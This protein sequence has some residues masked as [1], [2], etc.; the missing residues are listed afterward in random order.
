M[1]SP[2][3][4]ESSL[5]ANGVRAYGNPS[6][7]SHLMTSP[8]L[9][10]SHSTVK[11]STRRAPG[12]FA[13]LS[14]ALSVFIRSATRSGNVGLYGAGFGGMQ[15]LDRLGHLLRGQLRAACGV[16][17]R[18]AIELSARFTQAVTTP[19]NWACG[20]LAHRLVAV[21]QDQ[22]HAPVAGEAGLDADLAH[23][24]PVDREVGPVRDYRYAAGRRVPCPPW[25]DGP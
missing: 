22:R 21:H 8:C 5:L 6:P 19:G 20:F 3:S 11:A 24:L 15:L 14:A 9:C 25:R 16:G 1:H 10:T 4:V 18:A 12:F 2:S 23:A 7:V 17:P 13:I